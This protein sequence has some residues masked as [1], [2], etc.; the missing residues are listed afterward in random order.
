MCFV[1]QVCCEWINSDRKRLCEGFRHCGGGKNK[2]SKM[3]IMPKAWTYFCKISP[4]KWDSAVCDVCVFEDE[5]HLHPPLHIIISSTLSSVSLLV[6]IAVRHHQSFSV[7]L[8]FMMLFI[9]SYFHCRQQCGLSCDSNE[10]DVFFLKGFMK[11]IEEKG[12][13]EDMKGKDKIVFG[14]IHQIYDWHKEWVLTKQRNVYLCEKMNE[15][16]LTLVLVLLSEVSLWVNWR[17][18]LKIMRSCLSCSVNT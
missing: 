5:S 16:R 3:H 13:P 15:I 7:Y 8:L 1:F 14:N 11:R 18:V 2:K 6:C 9:I 4:S 10:F 17:N 12:V